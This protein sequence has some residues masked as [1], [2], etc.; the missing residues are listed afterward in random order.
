[1]F[2]HIPLG[3]KIDLALKQCSIVG[4]QHA[5]PAGALP[6]DQRIHRIAEQRVG[7]VRVKTVQIGGGAQI[8]QQQETT[9][10]FLCD[11]LRHVQTRG[12]HQRGYLH[13]RPAIFLRRRR[14]HGNP[15]LAVRGDSKITA[16][17]CIRGCRRQRKLFFEGVLRK[18]GAQLRQPR[19]GSG[20]SVALYLDLCDFNT[21]L[22]H[23]ARM[24]LA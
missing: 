5:G 13:E 2:A 11:D 23:V 10:D 19:I 7:I 17:T 9:V 22:R 8:A 3:K 6:L 12:A 4:R 16:K 20:Q 18:P 24:A 1:M 21:S 14:V 15:G